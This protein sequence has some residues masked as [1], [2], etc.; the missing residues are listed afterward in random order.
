MRCAGRLAASA[1]QHLLSS[2]TAPHALCAQLSAHPHLVHLDPRCSTPVCP[3]PPSLSLR[4]CACCLVWLYGVPLLS[5]LAR[6]QSTSLPCS[7]ATRGSTAPVGF[8]CGV[9]YYV[10]AACGSSR[11]L[12]S[13]CTHSHLVCSCDSPR[14][15]ICYTCRTHACPYPRLRSAAANSSGVVPLSLFSTERAV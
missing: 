12:W 4:A 15:A 10:A 3:V 7:L 11:V 2:L 9:T 13:M 5:A 6:A 1:T 14:D 8:P